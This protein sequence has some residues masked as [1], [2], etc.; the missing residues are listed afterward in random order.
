MSTANKALVIID[1]LNDFVRPDGA[2]AVERADACAPAIN[3]LRTAFHKNHGLV[4]YLCDAHHPEDPEF[5]D[6]PPHAIRGTEG[7]QVVTELAPAP[8][9][10]VVPKCCIDT[11]E[12]P[13]FPE[14]LG[15]R[16]LDELVVTGVATEHCVLKTALGGRE[17]GYAVTVVTDAVK[18]VGANEGDVD[19]AEQ[20]M[21][22]AGCRFASSSEYLEGLP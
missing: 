9:D 21:R 18:G 19:K 14:L 5:K 15:C 1:M 20:A 12:Q 7:A 10:F 17:R 3:R 8:G 22:D 16:E 2:L 4:I 6:W 13:Q 11:F